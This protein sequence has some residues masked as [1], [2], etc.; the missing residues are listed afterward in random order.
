MS[1][2]DQRYVPFD[3]FLLERRTDTSEVI[4]LTSSRRYYYFFPGPLY[5]I[6]FSEISEKFLAINNF[7]VN[8]TK[9]GQ[10][11]KRLIH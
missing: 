1:S 7:F 9:S 3:N 4:H 6:I 2:I 8:E 10:P 11:N 5:G